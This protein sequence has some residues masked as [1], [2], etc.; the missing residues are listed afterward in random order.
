[1]HKCDDEIENIHKS[2]QHLFKDEIRIF[3]WLCIDNDKEFNSL[4][5]MVSKLNRFKIDH[6]KTIGEQHGLM[7]EIANTLVAAFSKVDLSNNN[8]DLAK[9]INVLY[10]D[11]V[12]VEQAA[13]KNSEYN[14][15]F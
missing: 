1:L 11:P 14:G 5:D 4:E 12:T 9:A 7:T 13:S 3:K 15:G 2:N 6:Q 8:D 10:F